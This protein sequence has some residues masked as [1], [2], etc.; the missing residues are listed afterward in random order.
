M[1]DSFIHETSAIKDSRIGSIK[2]Y[3]NAAISHSVIAD[4]CSVGDDTTIERCEFEN[5]V[6]VNRRSYVNDSMVGKY[7]YMGINTTM[8]F[9]HIGRFCSLGRNVDIGGMTHDYHKVTTMPAFRYKQTKSGGGKIPQAPQHDVFCEIGNDVW[10]AAGAQVMRKVRIGNGA[11]VGGGAVVTKDVPP[12][13][14]VAG[15]P[16]KVIGYR[17]TQE[18]AAALENLKWWDW[19]ESLLDEVM[20]E[21]IQRDISDETIGFLREVCSLKTD[22]KCN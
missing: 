11:V 16:A 10:I 7:T 12:Y 1:D 15:V 5:N 14:I 21:L 6:V 8:N 13:A 9:T 19:P 22:T 17:C 4:G 2:I 20:E 3:K 18:Q